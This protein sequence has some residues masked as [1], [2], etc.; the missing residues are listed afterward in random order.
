MN[1]WDGL[2]IHLKSE[3]GEKADK[4]IMKYQKKLEKYNIEIERLKSIQTYEQ[5]EY[6]RG[7]IYVCGV[8]EVGRGP[9]AGP[10]VVSSVILP[11]N[12]L[13]EGIDD[14]KKLSAQ[15]RESLNEEI[16]KNAIEYKIAAADHFVIDEINILNAT[17]KAMVDCILS[18]EHTPDS[19]L[20]DALTLS[21]LGNIRQVPIIKGDSKSMSI[22][23]ASI[24]AKVYRDELMDEFDKLY[25]GYRFSKNKGYGTKEHIDAIREHGPCPIHRKTFIKNFI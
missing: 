4:M 9:L 11:E 25:P 20:I 21:G 10:V 5:E 6:K 13:I 18:M 15:K 17:K 12:I 14:S 24:V 19:V 3:Y 1:Q 23:A 22:A 7:A 2:F 8:D 16:I